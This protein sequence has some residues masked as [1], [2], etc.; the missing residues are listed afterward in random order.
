MTFTQGQS[1]AISMFTNFIGSDDDVMIM[2]GYAGTG[3]TTIIKEF[4]RIAN[5]R[6]REFRIFAPTGR[7]ALILSEKTGC[8]AST[9]HRGIYI[10]DEI[11]CEDGD[12]ETESEMTYY[13]PLRPYKDENLRSITIVDESS[14]ISSRFNK[15]ELLR[16]GSG[17]LLNDLMSNCGV[18]KGGKIVFVG[19]PAQLPPVGDSDSMALSAD[20][21]KSLGIKAIETELTEVV[22]QDK[23]SAILENAT[24]V[25][26]LLKERHR[27][28]LTLAKKEHE[29]EQIQG[30]DIIS[31]YMDLSP[32]P[33]A[34]SPVIICWANK[35]AYEY[36]SLIREIMYKEAAGVV[37]VGDRII[38]INNNYNL[39]G[40]E[41]FNGE[42]AIIRHVSPETT[43]LSAPVYVEEGEN[44]IR[45]EVS[46]TYRDISLEFSDG[47]V[48]SCKIV[49]SLLM[50]NKKALTYEEV[51]SAFINFKIRHPELKAGSKE[52]STAMKTDPYLNAI[53]A[54]FGYAITGHKSQG[55]E[56]K[57]VFADFSGRTGITDDALRWT[58]TVITRARE[59]IYASGLCDTTPYS[60]MDIKSVNTLLSAVE[61]AYAYGPVPLTPFHG[62]GTHPAIRAQ[63]LS[64]SDALEERGYRITGASSF[65]YMERYLVSMLDETVLTFDIR[66]NKSNRFSRCKCK[67]VSDEAVK[68]ADIIDNAPV[69]YIQVDYHPATAPLQHLYNSISSICD[70]EEITITNI[71][72]H[73]ESYKVIYYLKTSGRFS[74]IT[75]YI[76]KNGMFTTVIPVSDIENDIKLTRLLEQISTL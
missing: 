31:R 18:G 17:I 30:K 61:E 49:D 11:L 36:N 23:D 27:N 6:H 13:Y 38:V 64:I 28:T 15:T 70:E 60:K 69:M 46:L 3:K 71:V 7:A 59:C 22:R 12:E 65:P 72:E 33:S 47:I 74:S 67:T 14:M 75:L 20:Y 73:L 21:F 53:K 4:I 62:E 40:R 16:F 5:E 32:S 48:I 37:Q 41:I 19:D 45:K 66:Y 10:L 9:I 52:F 58:Y 24:K 29:F 26:D 39:P 2:K 8:E 54:K 42:F 63:F 50:N 51:C 44:C 55:G 68:V 43:T 57:T 56:W 1:E 34:D 76:D 25:R 35:H